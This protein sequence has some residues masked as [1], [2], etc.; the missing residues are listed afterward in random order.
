M[1]QLLGD[2]KDSGRL[3]VMDSGFP[4]LRLLEDARNLWRTN[5]IATQ[6]GK[7]AHFP[8]SH[9]KNVGTAKGF[10]RGFSKTF[11]HKAF[12][13]TYLNDNNNVTFFDNEVQSGREHWSAIEVNHGAQQHAI[14]IPTVAELYE[15]YMD[16]WTGAINSCLI[17]APSSE[18][19]VSKVEFSI[20]FAKCMF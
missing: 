6:Q 20:T 3:V 2:R 19:Y 13:I 7:T 18:A 14:H 9:T 10:A 8:R 1:E 16:G 17:I 4:T 12:T 11:H 5:I 15:R